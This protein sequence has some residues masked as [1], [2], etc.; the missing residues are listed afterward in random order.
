P[1]DTLRQVMKDNVPGAAKRR[2]PGNK[3]KIVRKNLTAQGV[4]QELHCDGHEKLAS[5]ALKMGPIGISIY[6]FRDKAS[7]IVCTLE[8]V[9]DARQSV[10]VGHLYLD[11]VEEFGAFPL[12]VTVDKGS[13]TG[14][15]YASHTALRETYTPELDHSN[16]DHISSH[17]F[18]WLWSRI[19]QLKLNE[20]KDYWNYHKT[21]RND[22]KN[23]PCGT[24]PIE[25]FRNPDAYGLARLSNPVE[26]AAIDALRENL[27]Y[28][29]K[30]AL[31]WVPD[32][33]ETAAQEVYEAIG[34]PTLEPRRGWE[35]FSIMAQWLQNID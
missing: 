9:P 11:L 33:F 5:A 16:S 10:V 26:Q 3:D 12:Q 22:K 34:S 29:R 6:S 28:T 30:E 35:I 2:Y 27:Q 14:E 13:E 1:S 32:N 20:F 31:R 23:L 21:R 24:S 19:V 18:H 8:A 15:M 17:L 7:G 4:F 25:I